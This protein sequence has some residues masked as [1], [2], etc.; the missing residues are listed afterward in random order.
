MVRSLTGVVA[1]TQVHNI[2]YSRGTDRAGTDRAGTSRKRLSQQLIK[3]QERPSFFR[4]PRDEE[5]TMDDGEEGTLD[6]VASA[7]PEVHHASAKNE[8]V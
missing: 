1:L 8:S 7:K 4:R 2:T 6:V 3:K 5:V